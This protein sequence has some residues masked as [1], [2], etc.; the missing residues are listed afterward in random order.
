MKIRPVAFIPFC[1]VTIASANCVESSSGLLMSYQPTS[2][3][4]TARRY[5]R[6]YLSIW[7]AVT[8]STHTVVIHC[9]M[10]M[11]LPMYTMIIRIRIIDSSETMAP[12]STEAEPS[13]LKSSQKERSIIGCAV[14]MPVEHTQAMNIRSLS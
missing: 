6:L 1:T 12:E 10:N 2:W 8:V 7:P 13:D 5:P 3:R 14:P 9:P 11:P 4:S